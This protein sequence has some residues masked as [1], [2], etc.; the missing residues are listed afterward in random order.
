MKRQTAVLLVAMLGLVPMKGL[1]D[2]QAAE[3]ALG[4]YLLGTKTSMAGFVPPPGTYLA[5]FNY[6]YTG[7]ADINLNI[8]GVDINGG[9]DADAYIKLFNG[10]WVA[11][12]KVLGGHAAFSV[13]VPIGWKNISAQA[14]IGPGPGFQG[15]VD[16]AHIGDPVLGASLGWHEGNWHWSIG[17]LLNVPIGYWERGDPTNIGFNRWAADFTGAVTYLDL[18]TGF[19]LS[20]AAGFTFNGE[21]DETNYKTGTEFHLEGAVMQHFSKT[22]ALGLQGYLYQQVTG[23]SGSGAR[24]G[25]FEGR[26]LALGPAIDFSFALGQ[27]PISGNLRYFHEFDVENRL[28]GDA[29]YLNFV[30]PLSGASH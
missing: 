13:A 1:D 14:G 19:E 12:D 22:F 8:G 9:V 26:V 24:L 28:E 16:D 2:V 20:G 29:G 27:V 11:P 3:G 15:E 10:L 18:K 17:T 30:I 7:S 6:Y 25:D 21:N 4:F 5:D 23:D